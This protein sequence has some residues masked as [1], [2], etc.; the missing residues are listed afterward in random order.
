MVQTGSLW[1]ASER[2][3]G[4]AQENSSPAVEAHSSSCSLHNSAL[5]LE[6][7]AVTQ[8]QGDV[9]DRMTSGILVKE[10]SP[11]ETLGSQIRQAE[12]GPRVTQGKLSA[13]KLGTRHEAH[14]LSP[15]ATAHR[16]SG[17]GLSQEPAAETQP[18]PRSE[19][20]PPHPTLWGPRRGWASG[21]TQL[22][23]DQQHTR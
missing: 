7:G 9:L 17:P 14:R 22:R 4:G 6:P 15:G 19:C 18:N 20:L 10:N 5:L 23:G 3:P 12:N 2:H 11:A 8:R 21:V 16:L 13:P 1:G